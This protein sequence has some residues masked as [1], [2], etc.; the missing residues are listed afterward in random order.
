MLIESFFLHFLLGTLSLARDKARSVKR[1]T[2]WRTHL[3]TPSFINATPEIPRSHD[4]GRL[5]SLRPQ[6]NSIVCPS[7]LR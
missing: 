4:F 3:T 1:F 6:S 2:L 5:I 7:A